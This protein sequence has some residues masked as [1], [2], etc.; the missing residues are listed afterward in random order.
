[1]FFSKCGERKRIDFVLVYCRKAA[2][3]QRRKS[4]ENELVESG[5]HLEYEDV[6]V[7]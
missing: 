3:D 7:R 5:L 4:F 2:D 6:E 1:M